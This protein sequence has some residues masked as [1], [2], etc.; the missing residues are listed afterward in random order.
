MRL[1][2]SKSILIGIAATLPAVCAP[3]DVKEIISKSVQAN[4]VDFGASPRFDHKEL[5]VL[6]NGSK[7]YQVS[8]MEGSP[9]RR[10]IAV[11]KQP[12]AGSA[13]AQEQKK[14][15]Q[16]R[17][18]RKSES[19]Q[20][21]KS[22]VAK[23]ERSRQRDNAM[24]NQLTE[25]FNF[26]LTGESTERGFHVYLLNATPKPGYQ[27]PN[28][29]CEVL[30]G[31]E[32][33]LWIDTTTFQWVKVQAHVV[34]PVSISGF[35]AEVEPGT[36]FELEKSPVSNGVWLAS[37]FAMQADAKVLMLFSKN[38]QDNQTFFDFTPSK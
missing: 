20:A 19:P 24:M 6:E 11:D 25:A 32:G 27:P 7:T 31:M 14:E 26:S 3:P 37:H 12:L 2:I 18:E 17:R 5:D 35:L 29:D 8:M 28:R 9:Y 21:H 13:E 38:S 10:L 34:R 33:Q 23:Y 1:L 4:H 30:P 36:Q 16:A 15:A 22:R